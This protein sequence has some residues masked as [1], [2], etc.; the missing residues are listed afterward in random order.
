MD[1]KD[2]KKYAEIMDELNL[3][4]LEIT[5]L[6]RKVRL[7]RK[8]EGAGE[9]RLTAKAAEHIAP[10]VPKSEFGAESAPI[11]TAVPAEDPSI[12]TLS[13]PMIGAFYA[14]PAENQEPFVN[15][16]DRVE[17]GDVLCIIESMKLM[18]E[19]TS[20]VAGVIVE[21]CAA[22]KQPIDYGHPLFKIKKEA[23]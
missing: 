2:I 13:S 8:S 10:S 7:E 17:I 19:I 18:N 12:Y 1:P 20:D 23:S 3:S 5:R 15:V 21:V 16:G 4:A 14:A 11:Q 6:G 22:N 9:A